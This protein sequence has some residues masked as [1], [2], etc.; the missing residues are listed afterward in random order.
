MS[1]KR[2]FLGKYC[3]MRYY[4]TLLKGLRV[5]FLVNNKESRLFSVPLAVRWGENKIH[6]LYYK[7][8]KSLHL[9]VI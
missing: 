4:V 3:A 5:R 7:K 8:L 9:T 2:S 6:Y 1:Y